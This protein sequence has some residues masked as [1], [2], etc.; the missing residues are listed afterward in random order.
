MAEP[1]EAF[2]AQLRAATWSDHGD[3]E[4]S[5]YMSALVGG[6]LGREEY[7]VLVAQLHPVYDTLERAAAERMA[8]DPV[9]GP[10]AFAD[11]CR[12]DALEADLAFYYGP[13]WRERLAPSEAT[14]RYCDRLREICFDWPGGFVAHHYTRYLGDLSGGQYIGKQVQLRLGLGADGDGVRFYRFPGKPKGYKDRYRALLDAAPWDAAERERIIAEVKTA[15][16]LNASV[17]EA[18]GRELKIPAA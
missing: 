16:R 3:N 5:S 11:L 13:G 6:R 12:R 14:R 8:A 17:T 15:Y 18:L 2:S 9:A 10:F 4:G 7:A 1:D